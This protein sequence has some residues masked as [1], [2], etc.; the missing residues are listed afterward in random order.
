MEI[1][2]DRLKR[3]FEDYKEK[4]DIILSLEEDKISRNEEIEKLN[5][6]KRILKATISELEEVHRR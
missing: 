4:D 6:E 3:E 2:T 1:E 5:D